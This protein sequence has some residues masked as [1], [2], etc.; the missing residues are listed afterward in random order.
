MTIDERIEALTMN[1]EL[2]SRDLQDLSRDLR[3]LK[4]VVEKDG[5]NIRALTLIAQ[6]THDSIKMLE[7]VVVSHGDRLHKLEER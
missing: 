5:D 1:M 7:N 2:F 3:E 6:A 4:S